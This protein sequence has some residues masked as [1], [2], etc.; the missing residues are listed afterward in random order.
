[1]FQKISRT[2][3]HVQERFLAIL[4]L[5]K[6]TNDA[7]KSVYFYLEKHALREIVNTGLLRDIRF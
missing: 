4:I 5:R 6:S 2:L 1:M 7:T 3:K